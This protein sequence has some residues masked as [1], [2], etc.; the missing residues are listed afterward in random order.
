MK[1]FL[2]KS[3]LWAILFAILYLAATQLLFNSPSFKYPMT[4]K[5]SYLVAEKFSTQE[6]ILPAAE[7]LFYSSLAL[8]SP[9]VLI[10]LPCDGLGCI[11]SRIYGAIF[12]SMA[13]IFYVRIFYFA[14]TEQKRFLSH[15]VIYSFLIAW[16]FLSISIFSF[17][18]EYSGI[19]DKIFINSALQRLHDAAIPHKQDKN[20]GLPLPPSIR[21]S[22]YPGHDLSLRKP[23]NSRLAYLIDDSYSRN[24]KLPQHPGEGG[25]YINL[26]F[27]DKPQTNISLDSMCDISGDSRN[28]TLILELRKNVVACSLSERPH[29]FWAGFLDQDKTIYFIA[30]PSDYSLVGYPTTTIPHF[31]DYYVE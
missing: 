16:S 14:F 1:F 25:Y 19:R 31:V 27:L 12:I 22:Y 6:I 2:K 5:S 20:T 3:L 18:G 15:K 30:D 7:S 17:M 28:P 24:S 23:R 29:I 8:F 26:F 11:F 4:D 13:F 10:G 21:F 9:W